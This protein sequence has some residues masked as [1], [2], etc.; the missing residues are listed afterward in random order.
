MSV[1]VSVF[2]SKK[3]NIYDMVYVVCAQCSRVARSVPLI[4]KSINAHTY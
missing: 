1:S 2:H 3:G 4:L